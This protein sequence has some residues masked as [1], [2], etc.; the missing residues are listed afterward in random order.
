MYNH[1]KDYLLNYSKD[2]ELW[3]KY[4]V[5][6][7]I[8]S[9]GLFKD[10]DDYI[11]TCYD[12]LIN[13]T[14]YEIED[15]HEMVQTKKT[16]KPFCIKELNHI[17]GVNV[18]KENQKIKFNDNV[19][20][21]FGQN[22]S[23][24]SGYFRIL[25]EICGGNEKKDIIPNIFSSVHKPIEVLITNNISNDVLSWNNTCRGITLYNKASVYDTSYM[26]GLIEPRSTQEALIEPFGLHLFSSLI[27]YIEQ[28]KQNI[29]DEE[30]KIKSNLPSIDS[31]MFTDRIRNV[32]LNKL[33]PLDL[34]TYILDSFSFSDQKNIEEL[35][36]KLNS[37]KSINIE[38]EIS[39]R[40]QKQ[41][42]ASNMLSDIKSNNKFIEEKCVLLNSL[43]E[44]YK[45]NKLKV[46]EYQN[47]I[48]ILNQ[49]PSIDTDEWKKFIESAEKYNKTIK[50]NGNVCIY[51]RNPLNKQSL[52]LI[53]A[54]SEYLNNDVIQNSNAIESGF[55]K[56]KDSIN[57][58]KVI[59]IDDVLNEE[60][61]K[62]GISELVNKLNTYVNDQLLKLNDSINN[63]SE[64]KFVS[65]DI[66]IIAEKIDNYITN[67]KQEIEKLKD[68]SD[69]RKEEVNKIENELTILKEKN[70]IVHQKESITKW[71]NDIEKV[72]ELEKIRTGI[73]TTPIS[74]LSKKA[75]S[76]LL[77]E[78]L[79]INFE[80]ELSKLGFTNLDVNLIE[81]GAS[82]GIVSTK[83][84][85]SKNNKVS[86]IL[87]EGEQKAVSLAMFLAE[88]SMR[89]DISPIILDDPVNSLDHKVMKRFVERLLELENQIII[90]THN[91]LFLSY[92][93]NSANC[94]ICKNYSNGCNK[95][96]GKH[97]YLYDVKEESKTSKG[98][99]MTKAENNS[100]TYIE[101][102]K[103]VLDSKE[104][105]YERTC[106]IHLRYAIE[107]LIDEKILLG[108]EP[109]KYSGK[110]NRINWD[111]LKQL[112]KNNKLLECLENSYDRLSGGKTH[113]GLEELENSLQEYELREIIDDI[114]KNINNS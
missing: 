46:E 104:L 40:T 90:F 49:I 21:L 28:L 32:F 25:N 44:N 5:N 60:F 58:D 68:T 101:L 29:I 99:I 7:V 74:T 114:E 93:E 100:S 51:C 62:N 12:I 78:G 18:L 88:I 55:N 8:L 20:I 15:V 94:H 39:L 113:R 10:S 85:V 13:G 84:V 82:K 30:I 67:I 34:K 95:N 16:T 65:F 71:I 11:S 48:K 83:L 86:D 45:S 107:C 19:T 61:E 59:E 26:N 24:K 102:A 36:K 72:K 37:L 87:S 91:I 106:A 42:K 27:K 105:E 43:I 98:V 53:S 56:L 41:L 79:K 89:N 2:K 103:N 50:D 9:N 110:S 47:K 73:N 17:S 38:T 35:E 81:A 109:L 4:L 97:V 76:K 23:G 80:S 111:S 33:L 77:T 108:I 66:N 52:D 64:I 63:K 92:F 1:S 3:L 69:K 31:S 6:K 54:Y 112:G 75:H 70:S 22:G 96:K 14:N 57:I